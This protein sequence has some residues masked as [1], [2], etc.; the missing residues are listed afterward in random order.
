MVKYLFLFLGI[1]LSVQVCAQSKTDQQITKEI[2]KTIELP[3]QYKKEPFYYCNIYSANIKWELFINDVQMFSHYQGKITSPIVPLNYNILNSGKQKITLRIYPA[4]E[5]S[6]LGE[7]ATFKMRLFYN[8]NFRDKNDPELDILNFELPR[9]KTKEL[10]YF[11]KTFEF[12]AQVP[13]ELVGW[14]KSK[15]LTKVPNLETKVLTKIEELH[16]ILENRDTESYIK[17][18]M[19][20][21]KEKYICLY[22]TKEEIEN[23]INETSLDNGF[24]LGNFKEVQ[25]LPVRNYA[26]VLEPNNRIVKIRQKDSDN[27]VDG[28]IFKGIDKEDGEEVTGDFLFRFHIP[29][30]SEELEVIR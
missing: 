7:Y 20:R 30:G 9:E 4:N 5:Q 1:V 29:E 16:K 28:I 13:Y 6:K 17:A 12:D 14:T 15:D 11:E 23:D 24:I 10:P 21:S 22:A 25:I 8:E 18:I 2:M 19:P 26:L 27:L 3:Q